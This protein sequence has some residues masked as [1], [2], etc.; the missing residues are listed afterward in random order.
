[1]SDK[2][3]VD[4][5]YKSLI[6]YNEELCG[7]NVEI[8]KNDDRYIVVLSDGLGSGV[9]ANILSTLTAKIISTMLYEGSS[10]EDTV[11]TIVH[12]LPICNVRKVAYSTF[13]ILQI[14]Y[15]GN[16]YLVEFDAPGCIF[17]RNGRL[18]PIEYT[19]REIAGKAIREARFKVEPDDVLTLMSDGVVYAGI[20]HLMNLGWT[21]E[22]VC[23]FV[24][25]RVRPGITSA[26]LTSM[27]SDTCNQLYI[28]KPGD[29]TTVATVRVVPKKVVSLYSGP[30]V[31]P[32]NDARLV[33]EF[34]MTEG[35]K[36]VCGGSSANIVSRVLKEP[37]IPS[38]EYID[39]EIPPTAEIPSIDLVT[40]GVITLKKT[41][42]IIRA[43]VEN[44]TDK[45]VLLKL[46]RKNGAS[47][48]AKMLIEECTHFHMFI[49]QKINPAHQNPDLPVD[50]SIKMII[51]D[52]LY[53][54]MVKAGKVVKRNYY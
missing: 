30:P 21:W 29:D 17:V 20:G 3:Y 25:G 5:T 51:M 33:T 19:Y 6:K 14:D 43:Y 28:N 4:A 13:I 10:I 11:D 54:L 37:L 12:T 46:D 1:M 27:L 36:I 49:G 39:P 32:K 42:D 23:E 16:A 47:L 48:I 41:V 8:V 7:D 52:E 53:S 26:R 38:L 31:N 45:S 44:P 22:N 35:K 2:V 50:L 40:E 24:S 15:D 9:K 34:M 18:V